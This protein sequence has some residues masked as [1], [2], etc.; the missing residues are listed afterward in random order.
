MWRRAFKIYS[1]LA[2]SP[3]SIISLSPRLITQHAVSFV[4]LLHLL[5][6]AAP[7]RVM[8]HGE[9]LVETLYLTPRCAGVRAQN[10]IIVLAPVEITHLGFRDC[11]FVLMLLQC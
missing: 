8:P 7:V 11:R 9:T 5:L 4:E 10:R 6:A 2:F 3:I 1:A